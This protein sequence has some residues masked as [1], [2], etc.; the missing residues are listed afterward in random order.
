MKLK[1][2]KLNE[3]AVLPRKANPTD[4]G[5]DI[6]AV[7]SYL[8]KSYN[9][10]YKTGIAVEIP[11]GY[12]GILAPRSSVTNS[13]YILGNGIGIIDSGFRGEL[14]FKFKDIDPDL[15]TEFKYKPGDRI[16]QLIVIPLPQFE[17]EFVGELD[18]TNDRGGG[19]GSSGA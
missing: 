3:N 14:L 1:F 4:A 8:D 17:P 6:V 13:S 10:V 18:D 9:H 12:F 7:T 15:F 5:F 2:K 11:N 19:F 16:G